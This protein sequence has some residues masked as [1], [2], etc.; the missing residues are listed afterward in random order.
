MFRKK[1]VFLLLILTWVVAIFITSGCG[2]MPPIRGIGNNDS[3]NSPLDAPGDPQAGGIAPQVVPSATPDEPLLQTPVGIEHAE[4]LL[5]NGDW[6]SA[7]NVFRELIAAP[8]TSN[9]DRIRA[10]IGLAETQL[11]AVDNAGAIAT[12]DSLIASVGQDPSIAQAYFLRGEAKLGQGDYAAAIT[13]LQTYQSLRPGI[14]DSYVYERTAD[15]FYAL[16]Q[17]EEGFRE[18]AKATEAPRHRVGN[19]V[20][21]EKVAARYREQ[22]NYDRAIEE[23][24]AI[25]SFAQNENYRGSIEFL[26]AQTLFEAQRND[27][28]YEKLNEVFLNY[29][30]NVEALDA[31]IVLTDAGFAVDPYQRGL[32]DYNQGLYPGAIDAFYSFIAAEPIDY[33]PDAHIYI[34]YSYR[35]LGNIQAAQS[36]LQALIQRFN[37]EDSR[38]WGDAWL[39]QA[40]IQAAL[41][42]TETAFETLDTFVENYPALPQAPDALFQAGRLAENTGNPE[43]AAEYYL[44]LAQDYPD[45]VRASEGLFQLGTDA[46]QNGNY[47][48]AEQYFRSASGV[49]S[50]LRPSAA[51]MWLGKSLSALGR[52]S[53]AEAAYAFA[54]EPGGDYYSLRASELLSEQPPF[55]PREDY[56][57]PDSLDE[58][59]EAAEQ[60]LVERFSLEAA[61]PLANGL[62][63]SLAGDSRIVRGLELWSLGLTLD[64]RANFE[65]VRTT[66]AEDPLAS[67]QLAVFFRD[68]GLYRSSILAATSV[69]NEADVTA[70]EAPE[71]IARLRYPIYFAEL[72]VPASQQY[73]IDP[74]YVF[75]LIFQE[76]QYEGFATSVAS[77]Q[78]LMQIWPPTG[79]DIANR[80]N[81]PNYRVSDLKRP[82]VSVSFGTWL[83]NEEFTRMNQDPYAVLAAYNAG[84][85]NSAAW[86]NAAGGDPDLF[87]EIIS[88]REPQL[89]VKRIYEHY[90]NYQYLYGTPETE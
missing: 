69:L 90:D 11:A 17:F 44:T 23:Y 55:S 72:I 41:G 77:A 39:E 76:S 80:L 31:L 74:L 81:W 33:Q 19:A 10:Q 25:L 75:S 43:R 57:L 21:R 12:L 73:G 67:Y 79:E 7:S 48:A 51:Q 56:D 18:Y 15:A 27:E 14:I 58:G 83:L 84:P 26:I 13:D 71:F 22:A 2:N 65:D 70:K 53:E 3:N 34:A 37:P 64:A 66:Y 61:A 78:G 40:D 45:D 68:I 54:A 89:Y 82:Y 42:D 4:R 9:E 35:Q 38:V 36:E 47:D 6:I 28:A 59:R 1:P 16:G 60:W 5:V 88:L 62:P 32:V 52:T 87:V 46:Y 85:G 29:P 8:D 30:N 86:Q 63:A 49:T 50:S 20:L 24:E